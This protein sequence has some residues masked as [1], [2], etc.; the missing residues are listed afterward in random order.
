M[1]PKLEKITPATVIANCRYRT[2]AQG[3]KNVAQS[4]HGLE[5]T[6]Q[7]GMPESKTIG[8][9]KRKFKWKVWPHDF[10]SKAGVEV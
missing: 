6:E 7:I 5:I 8:K 10:K 1:M 2:V 9:Q 4:V 3:F